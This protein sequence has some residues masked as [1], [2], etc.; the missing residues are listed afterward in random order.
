MINMIGAV[1]LKDLSCFLYIR[2]LSRRNPSDIFEKRG[3]IAGYVA[4]CAGCVAGGLLERF[5]KGIIGL[6]V[7]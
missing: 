1:N 7:V 5:R 3:I 6:V 4:L 2:Q